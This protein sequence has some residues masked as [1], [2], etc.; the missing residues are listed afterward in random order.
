MRDKYYKLKHSDQ[1]KCLSNQKYYSTKHFNQRTFSYLHHPGIFFWGGGVAKRKKC[2]YIK[3]EIFNSVQA[4]N[5][6]I[7]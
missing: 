7:S 5:K 3:A 1:E 4:V 6:N 2:D